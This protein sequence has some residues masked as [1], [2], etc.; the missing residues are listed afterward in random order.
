MNSAV[1][2]QEVT[3]QVESWAKLCRILRHWVD[4]DDCVV[5][6]LPCRFAPKSHAA[7]GRPVPAMI[8][9]EPC[10]EEGSGVHREVDHWYL[11]GAIFADSGGGRVGG[12]FLLSLS[13]RW[14]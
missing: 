13:W 8:D 4:S 7:S 5:L 3:Y 9:H 12:V 10:D 1:M 11:A 6:M 2:L 14:T